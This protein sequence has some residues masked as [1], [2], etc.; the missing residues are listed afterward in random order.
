MEKIFDFFILY[1]SV[2]TSNDFTSKNSKDEA[3]GSVFRNSIDSVNKL[4]LQ[5]KVIF[6]KKKQ[7]K[8]LKSNKFMKNL[9]KKLIAIT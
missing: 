7:L 3:F 8:Q 2:L 9:R 6:K 4:F 1:T 5:W